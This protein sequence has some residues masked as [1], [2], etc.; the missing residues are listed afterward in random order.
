MTLSHCWCCG[1]SGTRHRLKRKRILHRILRCE[2]E[3]TGGMYPNGPKAAQTHSMCQTRK[4]RAPKIWA[5]K[6]VCARGYCHRVTRLCRQTTGKGVYSKTKRIYSLLCIQ[7]R[8]WFRNRVTLLIIYWNTGAYGL[9]A[10][11]TVAMQHRQR[12]TFFLSY[13]EKLCVHI[14]WT[15]KVRVKQGKAV[16]IIYLPCPL[17]VSAEHCHPST[18]GMSYPR[19]AFPH[20]SLS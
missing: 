19:C 11:I 1:T 16:F 2:G 14:A 3:E 12:F 7:C 17:R 6:I 15:S 13:S 20:K 18:S 4:R 8:R 10:L 5:L 9:V